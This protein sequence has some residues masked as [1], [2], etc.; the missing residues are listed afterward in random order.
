MT[1]PGLRDEQAAPLLTR[2][3]LHRLLASQKRNPSRSMQYLVATVADRLATEMAIW[4]V[5]PSIAIKAYIACVCRKE[6]YRDFLLCSDEAEHTFL[7]DMRAFAYVTAPDTF[8]LQIDGLGHAHRFVDVL[9]EFPL[10]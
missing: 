9:H 1:L 2:S 4:Q 7:L 10:H 3:R 6:P 8:L 5:E